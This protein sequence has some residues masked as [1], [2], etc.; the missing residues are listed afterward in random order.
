M[1]GRDPGTRVP[2]GNGA[3]AQ[4]QIAYMQKLLDE[5]HTEIAQYKQG[6]VEEIR[7]PLLM[8]LV[9]IAHS[10]EQF[11]NRR[12]GQ[13]T[14]A[15]YRNFLELGVLTDLR[16]AL[17]RYNVEPMIC[18]SRTINRRFQKVER[19]EDTDDPAMDGQVDRMARGYAQGDRVLQKE[20]V[21]LYKLR[22]R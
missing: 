2:E 1:E 22:G 21:T 18:S 16:Q 9:G 13:V 6:L 14:A 10:V 19:L 3:G 7:Y 11:L 4:D 12:D 5:A 17:S 15:D 20:H 8:E